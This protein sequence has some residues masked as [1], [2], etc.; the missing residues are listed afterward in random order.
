MF[1]VSPALT[2]FAHTSK[3]LPA[4]RDRLDDPPFPD[5]VAE[6]LAIGILPLDATVRATSKGDARRLRDRRNI[7]SRFT[8][9]IGSDPIR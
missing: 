8:Y 4:R 2:F 3:S 6:R 9:L 1:C 7:A 5:E